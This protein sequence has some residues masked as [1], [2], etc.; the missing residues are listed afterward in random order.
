MVSFVLFYSKLIY[1]L[2]TSSPVL[3]WAAPGFLM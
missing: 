3:S 1:V 2:V